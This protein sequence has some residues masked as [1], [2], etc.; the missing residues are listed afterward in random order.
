VDSD[1]ISSKHSNQPLERGATRVTETKFSGASQR[2]E[3]PAARPRVS[4]VEDDEPV[5]SSLDRLLRSIGF[6]TSAFTSAEQLLE[7]GHLA[8][9]DCLVL[10]ISLP[11]MSGL[12][13]QQRLA[14]EAPS[15]PIIIASA[16]VDQ[17]I[18]ATA[19]AA[20]AVAFL[21]KPFGEK[22]LLEA[23]QLAWK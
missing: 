21:T 16:H 5:L 8:D 19:M 15:L 7:S 10:D 23:L 17:R 4:I 13:L 18:R 9:T 20:G 6:K 2:S 22:A 14:N 3:Q 1:F 11:G 12:E